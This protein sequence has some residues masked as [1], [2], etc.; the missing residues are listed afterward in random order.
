MS[1]AGFQVLVIPYRECSDG[2]HEDALTSRS[3]CGAW[4]FLS[5]G[6]DEGETPLEAAKREAYEE[7]GV[8]EGFTYLELEAVAS[9]PASHFTDR[10]EWEHRRYVCREYSFA[11]DVGAREIVLSHEHSEVRWLRYEDALEL[12]TWDSNRIALWELH[13]RLGPLGRDTPPPGLE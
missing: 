12:L 9:I 3:D 7:G 4:Q 10:W 6:G 1:R 5:G 8:A 13:A 11:V 2:S